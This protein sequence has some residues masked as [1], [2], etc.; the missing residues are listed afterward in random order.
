MNE[1][2]RKQRSGLGRF[3]F[4]WVGQLASQVGTVVTSLALAFWAFEMTGRATELG[5]VVF[6]TMFP[7]IALGPFIGVLVDRWSRKKVLIVCDLLAGAGTVALLVLFLTGNLRIAHLYALTFFTSLFA[8]FQGPS[9]IAVATMM[10]PKRHYGRSG[11]MLTLFRRGS[12]LVGPAL[13]GLLYPLIGLGGILWL[14]IATFLFAVGSLA[15]VRIPE[16][17]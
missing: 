17:E 10:L 7:R 13:A 14:D 1:E 5:L 3:T 8:A 11:G 9:L 4:I 12:S 6:F 16:V 2:P 15:L